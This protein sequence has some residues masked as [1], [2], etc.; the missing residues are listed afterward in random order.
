MPGAYDDADAIGVL[1]G[2][3]EAR[4]VHGHLACRD[5]EMDKAVHLLDLFGLDVLLRLEAVDLA[6]DLRGDGL[7]IELRD[8]A[9]AGFA[10]DQ[11]FPACFRIEAD[12]GDHPDAGDNNSSFQ[13]RIPPA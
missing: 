4:H 3:L 12:R 2:D 5:R 7:V 9:D 1:R 10:V 13:K 8:G 6:R 11:A